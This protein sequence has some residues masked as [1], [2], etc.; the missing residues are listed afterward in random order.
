MKKR[1]LG[2][3]IAALLFAGALLAG[4][5]EKA[6]E[7]Q[8]PAS[9][10]R[11]VLDLTSNATPEPISMEEPKEDWSGKYDNYFDE[12]PLNASTVEAETVSEGIKVFLRM[13]F[14]DTDELS[15][16][17]MCLWEG[18]RKK[19]FD[20]TQELNAIT[21]YCYS[22]GDV[23]I[24]TE[25]K[26]KPTTYQKATGFSWDNLYELT[27]GDHRFGIQNDVY[28]DVVYDHEET[29]DSVVY[30]VLMSKV[31][32]QTESKA[33]RWVKYYFY[34]NRET[35]AMDRFQIK[36]STDITDYYVFPI[37]ESSYAEL[38]EGFKSAKK[39]KAEDVIVWY[40][41]AY[42]KINMSAIGQ[43]PDEYN[44]ERMYGLK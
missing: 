12:H 43:D 34:I 18:K 38:P 27:M 25:L 31:L 28:E 14:I 41:I 20:K 19:E 11:A 2:V 21:L 9:T 3:R 33:N 1:G 32:R 39:I 16:V 40:A 44:L 26:G 4:C 10:E 42:L 29:I 7:T 24:S 5:G 6:A 17:R 13:S 35:Q 36:D 22:N 30:D 23:Y 8:E 37:D 15:Y